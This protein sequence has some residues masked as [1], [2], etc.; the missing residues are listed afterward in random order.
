MDAQVR[1]AQLGRAAG[2]DFAA[3]VSRCAARVH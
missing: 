3:R 2:A 1:H